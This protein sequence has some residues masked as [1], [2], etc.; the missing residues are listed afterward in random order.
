VG[1]IFSILLVLVLQVYL[2]HTLSG[3]GVG[4]GD[5][6]MLSVPSIVRGGGGS[7]GDGESFAPSRTLRAATPVEQQQQGQTS[8]KNR[9]NVVHV[10]QTRFMQH[11][12]HLLR[13]GKA[14]L[15]LFRRITLPSLLMQQRQDSTEPLGSRGDG[16]QFLWLIRV[17]PRLD[18]GLRR[19]FLEIVDDACSDASNSNRTLQVVI[20]ASNDNP[21]RFP[22]VH[23]DYDELVLGTMPRANTTTSNNDTNRTDDASNTTTTTARSRMWYG[24]WD[25]LQS[26]HE[27]SQTRLTLETRL[28][29]DDALSL[30]FID[31]L[32]QDAAETMMTADGTMNRQQ[33]A[34]SDYKVYCVYSHMEWQHYNPWLQQRLASGDSEN[35]HGNNTNGTFTSIESSREEQDTRGGLLGVKTNFCVTPGLTF[36]YPPGVVKVDIPTRHHR[37]HQ[38][39]PRC[40]QPQKSSENSVNERPCLQFLV[41]RQG[42]SSPMALRARTITSAGMNNLVLSSPPKETLQKHEA[43]K[44]QLQQSAMK[45][46][47]DALW[48][49]MPAMFGIRES[50]IVA[51]RATIENDKQGI[52]RD[53]LTGQCTKGHSCKHKARLTIQSLLNETGASSATKEIR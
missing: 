34:H 27:A 38:H 2:N 9:H 21:E 4:S 10:V 14:R 20:I 25:L 51:M 17:D 48:K 35:D 41:R 29:A 30:D 15:E 42:V 26:Y 18:P 33:H 39:L 43:M 45:N 7:G 53:A 11:Q 13:L 47:Q 36:A 32:Q 24:S 23:F 44:Q 12:P 40:R 16:G 31:R 3:G 46:R 19:E 50:D 37:I 28:D 52:L 5:G 8:W 6:R 1:L 49:H 22:K